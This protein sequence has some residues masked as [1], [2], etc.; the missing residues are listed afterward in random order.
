IFIAIA[1]TRRAILTEMRLGTINI[2]HDLVR[3]NI[4]SQNLAPNK[5]SVDAHPFFQAAVAYAQKHGIRVLTV[6]HGSYY[7]LSPQDERA[8]LLISK[9]T[10]LTIDLADS[11]I[12]LSNAIQPGF[13][14]FDCQRVTLT[15]FIIDFQTPPYT[16]V[17]LESVNP[18]RRTLT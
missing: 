2:C 4:A 14:L 10:D 11:T 1:G 5:E 7:F 6:D 15:H 9:T 3:L 12:H 13:A 8:Y 17:Q 16:H 18:L